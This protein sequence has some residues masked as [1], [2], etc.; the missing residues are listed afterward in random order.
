[1]ELKIKPKKGFSPLFNGVINVTSLGH[2]ARKPVARFS[3]LFNGVI[4]VTIAN[5]NV[6]AGTLTAFQSPI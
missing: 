6:S 5:I 4:N 1:M 3:P 2:Y